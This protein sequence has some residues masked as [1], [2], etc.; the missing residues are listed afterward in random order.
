[1]FILFYLFF[2]NEFQLMYVIFDFLSFCVWKPRILNSFNVNRQVF[3]CGFDNVGQHTH[4]HVNRKTGVN[5]ID[6]K[7]NCP[8]VCN[9]KGSGMHR[10]LISS[11]ISPF[12][13]YRSKHIIRIYW[14][15]FDFNIP[16]FC[17]K[18]MQVGKINILHP[19]YS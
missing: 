18:F 3:T 4:S 13:K 16:L 14:V 15:W 6:E 7:I 17:V 19:Q 5:V 10:P 11:C 1:M 12:Y 8:L 2:L 9:S